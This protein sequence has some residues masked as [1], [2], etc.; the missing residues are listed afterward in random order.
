MPV[1]SRTSARAANPMVPS[2]RSEGIGGIAARRISVTSAGQTIVLP[3][4]FTS[5]FAKNTGAVDVRISFNTDTAAQFFTLV[6]GAQLPVININDKTTVKLITA[7]GT[8]TI[9]A[10]LWG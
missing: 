4:K 1:S 5:F 7:S 9:E 3:A 10:I 2:F 8:S 6:A